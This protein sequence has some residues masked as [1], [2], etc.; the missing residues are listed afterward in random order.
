MT[1]NTAYINVFDRQ[2][3]VDN[4][5]RAR[6]QADRSA[7][8]LHDRA[9]DA[10]S[11]RLRDIRHNFPLTLHMGYL[12]ND[13]RLGAY[14]EAGGIHNLM[15]MRL[16][17]SLITQREG[18][19][20]LVGDEEALP[21]FNGDLDLIT[22]CGNLHTVND[23]PG[24]L[25]QMMRALKPDGAFIA[26]MPGGETLYEL[27]Q[28]MMT[29]EL[30]LRD[31]VA[32]R[33]APF[34]DKQQM[35]ALMQRAGFNLPVVD[36]DVIHVSYPDIFA[37]IRDLRAFGEGNAI[38]ERARDYPG[39]DFFRRVDD[40]YR[41][42]FGENDNGRINARFELIYLIGWRPHESQQKPL[43]PGSAEARLADV[44]ESEEV[45]TGVGVDD[46]S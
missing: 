18:V 29:A 12:G 19:Q 38:A 26:V 14:R 31:G 44:L 20:E 34:A 22:S 37:L 2:R 24:A 16:S 39:R 10:L 28:A 6:Q 17:P 43:K 33:V 1:G 15:H 40:T 46:D 8:F 5:K 45:G 11:D 21:F 25:I 13:A 41:A 32:P 7:T 36:S 23:L 3:L 30:E 35:G 9:F 42:K 4:D 27:R